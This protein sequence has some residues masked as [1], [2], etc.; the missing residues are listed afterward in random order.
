MDLTAWHPAFAELE[1]G[2]AQFVALEALTALL[3]DDDVERWLGS[4]NA[5]NDPEGGRPL[6]E[7][8]D[9]LRHASAGTTGTRWLTVPLRNQRGETIA[10]R[11]NA[12]LKR[13]DHPGAGEIVAVDIP[14]RIDPVDGPDPA[15]ILGA[16]REL[17]DEL[18]QDAVKA[19]ELSEPTRLTVSYVTADGKAVARTVERW[20]A[21]HRG[22][23]A[24]PRILDAPE[25]V[26]F[27][28]GTADRLTEAP[29]T[30]TTPR[31]ATAADRR[32]RWISRHPWRLIGLP[33]LVGV[34][35]IVLAA[36]APS[37]STAASV[38]FIAAFGVGAIAAGIYLLAE[39]YLLMREHPALGCL[40]LVVH[41]WWGFV[42]LGAGFFALLV[43]VLWLQ[44]QGG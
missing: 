27:G 2:V 33:L 17:E 15:S 4:L 29:E 26:D 30:I 20:S 10:L 8:R 21:R 42:V 1:P 7:L 22:L 24:E 37:L 23:W 6:G 11:Y 34:V 41:G 35:A 38:L 25:W 9:W 13:V 40:W 44:Y 12:A 14:R 43:A 39:Q 31:I 36:A 18:R 3:G 16:V 5:A 32:A 19:S 28:H